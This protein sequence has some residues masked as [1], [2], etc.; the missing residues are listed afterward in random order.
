MNVLDAMMLPY[1]SDGRTNVAGA[2]EN[3]R[4]LFSSNGGDRPDVPVGDDN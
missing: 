4:F 3:I 2:L 1:F